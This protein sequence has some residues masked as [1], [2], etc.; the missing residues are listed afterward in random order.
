VAKARTTFEKRRKE[1]ARQQRRKDKDER[2][3]QRQREK[4][5]RPAPS[6]EEDPD[7]AGVVPGPQP[8]PPEML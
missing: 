1:L 8:L 6:G 2:R 5:E 7:I 4:E 3:T